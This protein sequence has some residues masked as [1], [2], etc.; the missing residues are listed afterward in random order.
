MHVTTI[1]RCDIVIYKK[2]IFGLHPVPG[3]ELQKPLEF[4]KLRRAIIVSY[5][6]DTT[7]GTY[8]RMEAGCQGTGKEEKA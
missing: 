5:V 6:N 3:I 1:S 4:L 2:Y 8:L 7:F